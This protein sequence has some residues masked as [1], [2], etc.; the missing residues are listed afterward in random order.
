MK[1]LTKHILITLLVLVGPAVA[2]DLAQGDLYLRSQVATPEAKT[3][4]VNRGANQ[5][6][7]V[8]YQ[9]VGFTYAEGTTGADWAQLNGPSQSVGN[10]EVRLSVTPTALFSQDGRTGIGASVNLQLADLVAVNH[11]S[12]FGGMERHITS[13]VLAPKSPVSL[14]ALRIATDKGSVT[15][16][17]P[18][19]K[20]G[21]GTSIWYG[22]A[23]DGSPNLLMVNSNVRF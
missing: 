6:R 11:T 15:R 23:T 20:L 4:Q 19:V 9:G 17:G 7:N 12:H 16:V 10:E 5:T 3:V 14:Q 18:S 2:Q 8:N 21:S 13:A 22:V 1:N